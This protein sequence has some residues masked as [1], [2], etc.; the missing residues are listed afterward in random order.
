MYNMGRTKAVKPPKLSRIF[1]KPVALAQVATL[2]SRRLT[3]AYR[4]RTGKWRMTDDTRT[5]E[6][7]T[8]I[9][10]Q[11]YPWPLK[12][13][14]WNT[15]IPNRYRDILKYRYRIPNRL[16][17]NT[18]KIPNTDT[19][20]KYRHRPMTSLDL[21]VNVQVMSKLIQYTVSDMPRSTNNAYTDRTGVYTRSWI[22]RSTA[23]LGQ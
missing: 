18:D 21:P 11:A 17:K 19:D 7:W 5:N 1:H 16:E 4:S 10:N 6:R 2:I 3:P 8:N 12:W 14:G 22:V 13:T 9:G 20:V 15:E 23:G